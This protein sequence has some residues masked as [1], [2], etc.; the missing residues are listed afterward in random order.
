MHR[1]QLRVLLRLTTASRELTDLVP[2]LRGI[3]LVLHTGTDSGQAR[4]LADTVRDA[5]PE[6]FTDSGGWAGQVLR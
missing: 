5:D 3:D 6:D 2:L 1:R 4:L